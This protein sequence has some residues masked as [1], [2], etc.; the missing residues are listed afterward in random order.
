MEWEYDPKVLRSILLAFILIAG[1]LLF[2]FTI[3]PIFPALAIALVFIYI[4]TPIVY[5]LDRFTKKREYSLFIVILIFIVPF[6]IFLLIIFSS[7]ARE[8]SQLIQ[9][10]QFKNFVEVLGIN[11][12]PYLESG[13]NQ[14]FNIRELS[15]DEIM[16]S[17]SGLKGY[18]KFAG[19]VVSSSLGLLSSL[20][21]AIF[22]FLLGIFIAV[23]FLANSEKIIL[24]YLSPEDPAVK[25]YLLFINRGIKQIIYSIFLT[26]MI[27]GILSFPI[28]LFFGVPYSSIMAVSTGIL[29]IIPMVG[30]WLIYI[31]A[32]IYLVLTGDLVWAGI[33][34]AMCLVFISTVPDVVVRPIVAGMSKEIGVLPLI[35]G[36]IAGLSAFGTMGIILGP[37]II[38]STMGFLDRFVFP[39]KIINNP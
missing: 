23:V 38:I 36:F 20:G 37:V 16:N 17:L 7:M 12:K 3:K 8:I 30:G 29:S 1:S 32:G 33:F 21:G 26:A 24:K 6:T 27:A 19:S 4:S 39:K 14:V 5:F 34:V 22:Q 2:L 9:Q 13:A 10:P 15:L 31:P 28:Y 35:I 18:E 25:D 11:L